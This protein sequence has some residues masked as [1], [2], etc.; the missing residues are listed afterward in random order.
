MTKP[1]PKLHSEQFVKCKREGYLSDTIFFSF[2]DNPHMLPAFPT[3]SMKDAIKNESFAG[4]NLLVCG[5]FGGVCSS[6]HAQC[7]ELRQLTK[8]S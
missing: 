2:K 7:L 6:K 4:I 8:N 3:K 5:R 1:K